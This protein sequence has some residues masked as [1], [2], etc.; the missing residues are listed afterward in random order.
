MFDGHG[1]VSKVPFT[2]YRES[3]FQTDAFLHRVPNCSN[4]LGW[5]CFPSRVRNPVPSRSP[6][7]GFA[8]FRRFE[9]KLG[10]YFFSA[11]F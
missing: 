8:L 3:F 5:Q 9:F 4:S 10:W 1:A 7:H 6:N 11:L 2:R